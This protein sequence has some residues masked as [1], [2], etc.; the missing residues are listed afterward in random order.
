[1]TQT[2]TTHQTH[3]FFKARLLL[4]KAR[5][6]ETSSSPCELCDGGSKASRKAKLNEV[7]VE[8][9]KGREEEEEGGIKKGK[10]GRLA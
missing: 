5:V 8:C 9:R 6:L 1:M 10:A 7:G 4:F 3:L 2:Y